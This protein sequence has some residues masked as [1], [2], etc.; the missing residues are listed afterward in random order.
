MTPF[1]VQVP[2]VDKDIIQTHPG[3]GF[4]S[5]SRV[6]YVPS[7]TIRDQNPTYV[8][9]GWLDWALYSTQPQR[10]LIKEVVANC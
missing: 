4:G 2:V 8:N 3:M 5:N 7:S 6:L 9:T 10:L 1:M